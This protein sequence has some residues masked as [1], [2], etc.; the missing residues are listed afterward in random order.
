MNDD[1]ER[2]QSSRNV[3]DMAGETD[4]VREAASGNHGRELR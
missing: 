3:V 1:V 4:K 2:P